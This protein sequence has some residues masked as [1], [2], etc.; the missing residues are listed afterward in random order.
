MNQTVPVCY[1][2]ISDMFESKNSTRFGHIN[3]IVLMYYIRIRD[4]FEPKNSTRFGHIYKSNCSDIL[5]QNFSC[6]PRD[7]IKKIRIEDNLTT[8]VESWVCG[9]NSSGLLF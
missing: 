7:I 4:M 6:K 9:R 5:Y 1:I 3:Q 2:R 8:V